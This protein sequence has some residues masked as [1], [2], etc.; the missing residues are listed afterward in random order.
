MPKVSLESLPVRA[1]TVRR[2]GAH[3]ADEAVALVNER[4]GCVHQRE[5]LQHIR[6]EAGATRSLV[7][8][9]FGH[10]SKSGA[11]SSTRTQVPSRTPR[12]A[13][14]LRVLGVSTMSHTSR[15]ARPA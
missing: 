9:C 4:E 12:S 13:L 3:A 15:A 5:D 2:A 7:E 1:P 8:A 11:V 6:G 14:P 10:S